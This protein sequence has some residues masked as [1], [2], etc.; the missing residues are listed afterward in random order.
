LSEMYVKEQR[1]LDIS[2]N[3]KPTVTVS[4]WILFLYIT[5]EK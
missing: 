3:V 4:Y 5:R 2:P 1:R